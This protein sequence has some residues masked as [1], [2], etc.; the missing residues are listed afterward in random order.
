M[1][2]TLVCRLVCPLFCQSSPFLQLRTIMLKIPAA[3]ADT[4]T[5]PVFSNTSTL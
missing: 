1:A 2:L 3:A 5:R 4:Q